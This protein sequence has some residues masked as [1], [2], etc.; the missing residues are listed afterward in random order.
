MSRTCLQIRPWLATGFIQ[1]SPSSSWNLGSLTACSTK[2][3]A[4]FSALSGNPRR[5]IPTKTPPL[6]LVEMTGDPEAPHREEQE[7]KNLSSE[8]RSSNWRIGCSSSPK[9]VSKGSLEVPPSPVG[10]DSRLSPKKSRNLR[11][12]SRNLF[13]SLGERFS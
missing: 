8:S 7:H 4:P 6:T 2:K 1:S 13:W 3:S 12:N 10:E 11:I 5:N 9:M